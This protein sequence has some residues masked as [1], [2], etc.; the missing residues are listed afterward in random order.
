MRVSGSHT[1]MNPGRP[2]PPAAADE[3][4]GGIRGGAVWPEPSAGSS[5]GPG[6]P[7]GVARRAQS[8]GA[9]AA[10]LG[11]LAPERDPALW[12]GSCRG[13]ATAGV[14]LGALGANAEPGAGRGRP[15]RP[16]GGAV[17][18]QPAAGS[19]APL[20]N[21]VVALD[22][23]TVRGVPESRT[24]CPCG[25]GSGTTARWCSISC[26]GAGPRGAGAGAKAGIAE[27]A[28]KFP[29]IAVLTADALESERDLGGGAC[30]PGVGL[31]AQAQKH[32]R[33][34][35]QDPAY[36]CDPSTALPGRPR[37]SPRGMAGGK[38]G[39]DGARPIWWATVSCRDWP[40]GPKCALAAPTAKPARGT[41][42][43]AL[44]APICCR[45]GHPLRGSWS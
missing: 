28:S 1:P 15:D 37:P 8:G 10:G 32:P 4:P 42:R 39:T 19:A 13:V 9:G 34:R 16:A 21:A 33:T 27:M 36:L 40:R 18:L 29:G 25:R 31:A 3:V 41:S 17:V 35:W 24:R 30:G 26:R 7:L 23:K 11:E 45:S 5:P 22:G 44:W 20:A 38:C 2:L 14:A 12:P 6:S 43:C